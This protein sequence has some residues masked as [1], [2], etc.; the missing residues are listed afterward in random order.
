MADDSTAD[1]TRLAAERAADHYASGPNCA[2]AILR[3]LPEVL[4][5]DSLMIAPEAGYGWTAGVS[6]EVCLC[7]ALAAGVMLAGAAAAGGDSVQSQ[8]RSGEALAAG[9]RE[10][11]ADRWGGTC[12]H[13]IRDR[14][15][16]SDPDEL[17][18]SPVVAETAAM[19]A[20]LVLGEDASRRR[21]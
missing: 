6:N 15:P 13:L 4:G 10:A 19:L 2:E 16:A 20:A 8:R 14:L 1:L 18:C 11:F 9:V 5:D 12:C 17:R 21:T 7:G 3:A